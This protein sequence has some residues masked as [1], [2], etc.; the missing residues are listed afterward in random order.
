MITQQFTPD[1]ISQLKE[2][3]EYSDEGFKSL[4][5]SIDTIFY[6]TVLKALYNEENLPINADDV[7]A[8][9]RIKEILE[10][11]HNTFNQTNE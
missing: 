1:T 7:F 3:S 10:I 5:K 2:I 11:L 4:S 6:E 8:F 9:M